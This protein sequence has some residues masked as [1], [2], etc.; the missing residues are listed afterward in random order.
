M[1]LRSLLIAFLGWVIYPAWLAAGAVDYLCHR[2]TDIERTS[3]AMESWLHVAQL[4]SMTL[5][6]AFATLAE[7]TVASWSVLVLAAIAHSALA[8]ADVAYT[9]GRRRISPLEQTAHS[10]ME[11]LPLVAVGLLAVASWPLARAPEFAFASPLEGWRA[12]VLGSFALLAGVPVFEELFRSLRARGRV[13]HEA[14]EPV[15]RPASGFH[16]WR[17]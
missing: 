9:D 17:Q 4:A 14:R 11:V 7:I 6:V 1:E 16:A 3:G 2:K 5:I 12:A 13:P 10:F 15:A 8:F